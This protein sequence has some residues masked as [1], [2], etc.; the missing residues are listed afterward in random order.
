MHS[1]PERMSEEEEAEVAA[2]SML[3]CCASCGIKEVDEVKLRKC[4]C[5][6]V[7]YCSVDCQKIHRPQHKRACKKRAVELRD[8]LLFKQPERSHFGDCPICCVPLPLDPMKSTVNTCCSKAICDGCD[9]AN[10]TLGE[11]SHVCAF[12]R[13]PVPNTQE[14]AD[15]NNMRR[16]EANDPVAI[17]QMGLARY[18]ARDFDRAFEYYTRA[19]ELGDAHAHYHLSIMYLKGEREEDEKKY[20]HHL[21]EAAIG[22][23]PIARYNL[24][25]TEERKDRAE[26]AVKHY[27]IAANLGYDLS[28]DQLKKAYACG[29]VEKEDLAAAFRKHKAAK[30]AMDTPR[31]KAAE[32]FM[33]GSYE[34]NNGNIVKAVKHLIIAANL[35]CDL[36]LDKLKECYAR[37]FVEKEDLAAAFRKHHAAVEA[38][39]TPQRKEAEASNTKAE[40]QQN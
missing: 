17:R 34:W 21:E 33:A 7:K 1:Y 5:N 16:V 11:S 30:D 27:A 15:K 29:L 18:K 20:T 9:Y 4:A 37:G 6:L 35:G 13:H 38:M 26:R 25:I 40:A 10:M 31:R 19:A 32:A 22:G 2:D 23:H 28:L 14:E 8:E 3:V 12:C 39:N 24:A 36:S